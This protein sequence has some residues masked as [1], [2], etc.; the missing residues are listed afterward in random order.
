VHTGRSWLCLPAATS[1]VARN[2]ASSLGKLA[3]YSSF[4][5]YMY[6]SL[7]NITGETPV[8]RLRVDSDITTEEMART[9]S[10]LSNNIAPGPDRIPNKALK[11]YRPLIA[12]WLIDTA[13]AY[14]AIGYYPRLGRSI[15]TVI[16]RKEGKADYLIPGSYRLIALENTLSKILEKVIADYIVDT[17]KEYALLL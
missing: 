4:I 8:T 17:A 11:T 1:T 6:S 3:V 2:W 9:I 15:T 10:R 14:F 13:R 7:S 12:P 5:I 16:L